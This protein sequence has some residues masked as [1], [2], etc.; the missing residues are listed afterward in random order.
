LSVYIP[1]F[2]K[3]LLQA[4]NTVIADTENE[5]QLEI[6]AA[7]FINT[8]DIDANEDASVP[9]LSQDSIILG[10]KSLPTPT[11]ESEVEDKEFSESATASDKFDVGK[12]VDGHHSPNISR[13]EDEPAIHRLD[14]DIELIDKHALGNEQ[15]LDK[16]E[17]GKS[18]AG[19]GEEIATAILVELTEDCLKCSA[20]I[21]AEKKGSVI[22]D[23]VESDGITLETVLDNPSS[24]VFDQAL[25]LTQDTCMMAR[26]MV[27]FVPLSEQADALRS[28]LSS[29]YS[30]GVT[31]T[32]SQ[33]AGEFVSTLLSK[34]I[35]P[36]CLDKR[37]HRYLQI[38][39]SAISGLADKG[40]P[41][42]VQE[43]YT[44]LL[45]AVNEALQELCEE[46]A[47]NPLSRPL[48]AD[49]V[50]E[51][52]LLVV[53]ASSAYSEVHGENLDS[54]LIKEVKKEGKIW[55]KNLK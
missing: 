41:P 2:F 39:H 30:S 47:Q 43:R 37:S 11:P 45:D 42:A 16:Q 55:N 31:L 34:M 53:E 51:T 52:V 50:R 32:S 40:D 46:S 18:F 36:D 4:Y 20:D 19:R 54:M 27:T 21:V 3:I 22:V 23:N 48:S 13:V 33:F 17:N 1:A 44:L 9:V 15:H 7:A 25:T 8:A 14:S 28:S 24:T 6:A 12:F 49:S 38:P 26:D 35:L 10:N 29:V 5:I